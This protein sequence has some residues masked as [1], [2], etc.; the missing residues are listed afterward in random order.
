MTIDVVVMGA[1]FGGLSTA[2]V[3]GRLGFKVTLVEAEPQP[4]GCLRS[5]VRD[6]V[7]CPV[8]V[9]YIGATAPGEVLGDFIDVLGIRS[10]LKLRR[11]GQGGVIDRYVFDNE[12]FELPNTLDK[13]EAALTKRFPDANDAVSFV[14]DMIRSAMASLR[15]DRAHALPSAPITKNAA[16]YFADK[17]LPDR[18]ID[19]L[20][21][22]GF[23][24]GTNLRDCP[25]PFLSVVTASLLLSACELGSSGIVMAEALAARAREVGVSIILGDAVTAVDVDGRGACGVRLESGAAISASTVVAGIHPKTLASMLPEQAYPAVYRAGL[26]NL[27][28]TSGSLGVVALLDAGRHPATDYNIFRLRGEPRQDLQGIYIQL[29]PSGKPN[30]TRLTILKESNYADW[31][32]WHH[33]R[34]GDRGPDY[35]AEKAR[36]S[37]LV[38]KQAEEIIGPIPDARVLDAWTPLTLRDWVHAPQGGTYGV[39]HSIRDGLDYLVL[40]RPPLGNLFL[41]GQSAI[42]PG[43]LGI[44][45]GVMRVVAALAGREALRH[46]LESSRNEGD[47]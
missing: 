25:A 23:L 10:A 20:A 40:S 42:A 39:R 31:S 27:R 29:R 3:L 4:G 15:S 7:D 24:V 37:Q 41:V 43:L 13:L 2:I 32:R 21:V 47:L 1:G 9:H 30:L 28:E 46:L 34:K 5:Y 44:G 11:I 19:I 33:T 35:R 18:L 6:G 16:D 12:T 22:Q 36:Q 17:R 14:I 45:M 8:G 26:G 38:L